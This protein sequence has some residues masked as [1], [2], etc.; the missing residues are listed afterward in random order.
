MTALKKDV[1]GHWVDQATGVKYPP[2]S[3]DG[4]QHQPLAALAQGDTWEDDLGNVWTVQEVV[5][6]PNGTAMVRSTR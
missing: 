4:R 1:N 6:N 3:G 5:L 2:L